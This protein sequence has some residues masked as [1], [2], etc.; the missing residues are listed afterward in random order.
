MPSDRAFFTRQAK[1]L[2]HQAEELER[3]MLQEEADAAR[4]RSR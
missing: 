3:R 4:R 1:R 2:D